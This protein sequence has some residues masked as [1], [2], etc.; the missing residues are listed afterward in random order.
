MIISTEE[1]VDKVQHPSMVKTIIGKLG[2][3]ENFLNLKKYNYKIPIP[4]IT[5]NGERYK[6]FLFRMK[7][8]SRMKTSATII[9]S[10]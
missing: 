6:S 5:F 2:I 10:I 8:K 9:T 7:K 4:N 1:V 3:E